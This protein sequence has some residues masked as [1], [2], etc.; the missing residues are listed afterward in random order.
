[1]EGAIVGPKER[2]RQ[3][4]EQ[5]PDR[6]HR[7]RDGIR[8]RRQARPWTRKKQAELVLSLALLFASVI[9]AVVPFVLPT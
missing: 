7:R 2:E 1:M 5:R 4:A 6:S 3:L 9:L 8:G